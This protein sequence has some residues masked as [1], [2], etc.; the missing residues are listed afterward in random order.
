VLTSSRKV[1]EC[2]PKVPT[3]SRKLEECKPLIHGV[4]DS[5]AYAA[6]SNAANNSAPPSSATADNT[7]VD[8]AAPPSETFTLSS[9]GYTGTDADPDASMDV[10]GGGAFSAI[11]E[12]DD[13]TPHGRA[14]QVDPI[15]PK[16]KAPVSKRLKPN[17]D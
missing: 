13:Y 17:N 8:G 3:L 1:E 6:A 10:F 16:L 5:A 4:D 14:V 2:K 15:K 9:T 7:T 11:A 12:E